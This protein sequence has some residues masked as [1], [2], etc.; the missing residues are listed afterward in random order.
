LFFFV[1]L[2]EVAPSGKLTTSVDSSVDLPIENEG[3]LVRK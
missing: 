1:S 3:G 2:Q